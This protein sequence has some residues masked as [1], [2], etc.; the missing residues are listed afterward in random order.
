VQIKIE[1]K[2]SKDHSVELGVDVYRDVEDGMR[3]DEV[4]WRWLTYAIISEA[5]RRCVNTNR[6]TRS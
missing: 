1:P 2:P 5:T 6:I 4:R 3:W